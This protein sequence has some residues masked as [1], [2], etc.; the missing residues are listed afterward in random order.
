MLLAAAW[1][2]S[3]PLPRLQFADQGTNMD[4]NLVGLDVIG[5]VV[6]ASECLGIKKKGQQAQGRQP[7]GSENDERLTGPYFKAD[8]LQRSL[9]FFISKRYIQNIENNFFVQ[10]NFPLASKKNGKSRNTKK[11]KKPE[12]VLG[13]H[14]E[15]FQSNDGASKAARLHRQIHFTAQ[16]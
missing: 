16:I 14:L 8:M 1:G 4:A 6:A 15:G 5:L 11:N 2:F 10:N 7:N 12:P 13:F 9:L 3:G